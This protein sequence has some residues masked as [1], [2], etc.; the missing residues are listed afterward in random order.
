MSHTGAPSS[1]SGM[2]RILRL[3]PYCRG[4]VF[5]VL[6]LG[7]YW[8]W[9]L[10]NYGQCL[11]QFMKSKVYKLGLEMLNYSIVKSTATASQ[12]SAS[13]T[14]CPT[15]ESS[16]SSVSV[17]VPPCS[18]PTGQ[19]ASEASHPLL[20]LAIPP[21]LGLGDRG[22]FPQQLFLWVSPHQLKWWT[23]MNLSHHMIRNDRNCK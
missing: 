11:Q 10:K 12:T 19:L 3:Y 20:P 13:T 8:S 9:F 1:F 17:A 7:S 16:L 22:D 6:L 2:S 14:A 23:S 5:P 21:I 18:P 15:L 4:Q